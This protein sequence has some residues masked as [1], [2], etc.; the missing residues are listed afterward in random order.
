M[1]VL[2]GGRAK[3]SLSP[4]A[5]VTRLAPPSSSPFPAIPPCAGCANKAEASPTVPASAG[6]TGHGGDGPPARGKS[7]PAPRAKRVARGPECSE[8]DAQNVKR[9][10]VE[11]SLRQNH[12]C[13][14]AGQSRWA[15]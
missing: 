3:A 4:E 6:V 7:G 13:V 2:R 14:L 10:M 15:S 5:P 8:G 11:I 12:Q 1:G 9:V